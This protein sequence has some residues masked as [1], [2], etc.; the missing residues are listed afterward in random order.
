MRWITYA[1]DTGGRVGVIG[2]R[3]RADRDHA[4]VE[5]GEGTSR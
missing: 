3:L 5:C 1:S 2:E 4:G